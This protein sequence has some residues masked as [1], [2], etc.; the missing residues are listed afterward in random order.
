MSV[1]G[2][3]NEAINAGNVA[4][5]AGLMTDTHRFIDSAGTTVEGKSACIDAWRGFFGTFPDYRNVF[6]NVED[7]G[8]GA[9]SLARP[10]GWVAAMQ[11]TAVPQNTSLV[12]VT[13]VSKR[14]YRDAWLSSIVASARRVI[15][16]R[17]RPAARRWGSRLDHRRPSSA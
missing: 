9:V 17:R 4:A 1:V 6:D 3:F 12:A 13:I 15:G 11:G 8:G 7:V 14:E 16:G 5:L 2:L 10:Q